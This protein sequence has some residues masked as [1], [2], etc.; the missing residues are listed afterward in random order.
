MPAG[1]DFLRPRDCLAPITFGDDQPGSL[2]RRRFEQLP[3]DHDG[4]SSAPSAAARAIL[5]RARAGRPSGI[6]RIGEDS[7]VVVRND[8]PRRLI[9]RM[10]R[11]RQLCAGWL[12][13]SVSPLAAVRSA[14]RHAGLVGTVFLCL[15]ILQ[16]FGAQPRQLTAERIDAASD[17]L[18]FAAQRGDFGAALS[19]VFVVL[20]DERAKR[21]EHFE[22]LFQRR[23][24]GQPCEFVDGH[25]R[26]FQWVAIGT[27]FERPNKKGRGPRKMRRRG[28]RPATR[29]RSPFGAVREE[30]RRRGGAAAHATARRTSGTRAGPLKSGPGMPT[31]DGAPHRHVWFFEE[32]KDETS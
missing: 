26:R 19:D 32:A 27:P 18:R 4:P 5:R 31:A 9:L 15:Q 13:S 11:S 10:F 12:T 1:I 20:T 8:S 14:S 25:R 3:V 29:A 16:Y 23:R 21:F 17:V 24:H 6:R 28:P 22:P 2:P 30:M 7:R